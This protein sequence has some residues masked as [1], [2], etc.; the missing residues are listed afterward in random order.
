VSTPKIVKNLD[1]S[2]LP[3]SSLGGIFGLY[4][5][6]YNSF[7]ENTSDYVLEKVLEYIKNNN[8]VN[9]L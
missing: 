5:Q 7:E 6:N 1:Q 9:T 3:R 8:I 2:G 4:S